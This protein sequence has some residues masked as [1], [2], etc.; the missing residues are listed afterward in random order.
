MEK[1]WNQKYQRSHG[2]RY[3]SH[4]FQKYQSLMELEI[5]E[6]LHGARN[7]EKPWS[8]KYRRSHGARNIREAM[9]LEIS[10]KPW[11][12][13]YRRS[14]GARNIGEA[15]RLE[16]SE[17]PWSQKYQRSHGTRNIRE[18]M[19]LE[20]S[21]KPWSQKY[22]ASWSLEISREAMELDKKPS[23]YQS[24]MED[25]SELLWSQK[26][27]RSHGAP[28]FIATWLLL[29]LQLEISEISSLIG[30]RNIGEAM[31]LEISE[32][33][34]SQKYRRSHVARNIGEAMELEISEKPW[35]QKQKPWE[36]PWLLLNIRAPWLL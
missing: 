7:I 20:I 35:S 4:G 18:A 25:I 26:Y 24:L 29:Y 30:A 1:P 3:R 10:E 23:K 14:H 6:K 32:K 33:P 16:I 19:E 11:S 13:K 2:A 17:K 9:E 15:M 21:E 36:K 34:W 31:E 12:Q 28:I 22:L 5:S 27:R 8:Q